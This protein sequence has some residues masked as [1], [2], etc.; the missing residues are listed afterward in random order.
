MSNDT[1]VRL[2]ADPDL[3]ERVLQH[4]IVYGELR[5][6]DL[7]NGQVIEPMQGSLAVKEY[8]SVSNDKD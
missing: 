1:R 7:Y 6:A 3:L 8:S 2:A 5:E 4:H